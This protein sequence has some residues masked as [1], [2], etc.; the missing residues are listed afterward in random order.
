MFCQAGWVAGKGELLGKK[1]LKDMG[2]YKEQ[3]ILAE[4]LKLLSFLKKNFGCNAWQG[5]LSSPTRDES[6]LPAMETRS[7][8]RWTTRFLLSF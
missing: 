6:M 4:S 8:N 7:L 1:G 3:S 5:D 2:E